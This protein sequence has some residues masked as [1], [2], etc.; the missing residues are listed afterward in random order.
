MSY[1]IQITRYVDSPDGK[2]DT[3]G[4]PVRV[5][6]VN[7]ATEYTWVRDGEESHVGYRAGDLEDS[8]EFDTWLECQKA[9]NVL[10]VHYG[11]LSCTPALC[12]TE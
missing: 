2:L 3:A 9:C 12:E 11:N 4:K 8:L 6:L 5:V 10:Q 7:Y 1:V